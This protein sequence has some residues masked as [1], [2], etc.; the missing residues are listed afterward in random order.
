MKTTVR[1]L[2]IA[3]NDAGL[4]RSILMSTPGLP[5]AADEILEGLVAKVGNKASQEQVA[6]GARALQS[7]ERQP[8]E[9]R[10]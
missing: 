9:A 6:H 5:P 2:H 3:P 10:Q 8:R 1:F 4:A 7:G